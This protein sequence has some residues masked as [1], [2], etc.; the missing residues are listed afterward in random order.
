M[1]SLQFQSL[2]HFLIL[3]CICSSFSVGG[4]SVLIEEPE[5]RIQGLLEKDY[6]ALEYSHPSLYSIIQTQ[7]TGESQQCDH[8]DLL[9][10]EA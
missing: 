6:F 1:Q 4:M 2:T 7:R 5:R 10:P 3:L 8:N 9:Y